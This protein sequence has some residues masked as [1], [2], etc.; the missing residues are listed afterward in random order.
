MLYLSYVTGPCFQIP[1]TLSTNVF[2]KSS[3]VVDA[4]IALLF[5]I[6]HVH[7][8]ILF[9]IEMAYVYYLLYLTM[10][11]IP[12]CVLVADFVIFVIKRNNQSQSQSQSC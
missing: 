1:K 12:F 8:F 11:V 3:M 2:K 4:N 6:T 10:A 7:L 5:R 9:I